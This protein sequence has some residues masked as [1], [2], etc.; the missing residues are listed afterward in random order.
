MVFSHGWLLATGTED[1]EP[2]QASTGEIAGIY[3]VFIFFM[4]SGYLVTDS[5]LR[6]KSTLD[7]AVKRARRL[8]PA[9]IASVLVTSLL[10]VP[11]FV[12]GG[13]GAH[14]T[15]PQT[16]KSIIGVLTFQEPSLWFSDFAFYASENARQASLSRYVNGVLWTI[17]VEVLCYVGLAALA[18]LGGLRVPVVWVVAVA[19]S[20]FSVA[21][22]LQTLPVLVSLGYVAPSFAV[23]VAARLQLRDVAVTGWAVLWALTGLG[24]MV[25]AMPGWTAIEQLAFPALAIWPMLWLGRRQWGEWLCRVPFTR[26]SAD[27]SYGIY[28]WGWPIQQLILVVVGPQ[29][30]SLWFYLP[31][32]L[33]LTWVAGHL[34]W[35]YIERPFLAAHRVGT[36]TSPR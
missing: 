1:T 12:E 17:R 19:V 18:L 11:W 10:I 26:Q 21:Y 20:A 2:F 7:F 15:N 16:W 31:A 9:F 29:H 6:S 34:S 22:A 28:I 30:V 36:G 24:F 35:R 4:L 13:A 8:L 3:G 14:L 27:P 23:G 33:V 5:R 25:F 32:C